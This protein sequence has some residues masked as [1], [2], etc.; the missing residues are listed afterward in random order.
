MTKNVLFSKA[1]NGVRAGYAP[2]GREVYVDVYNMPNIVII[3]NEEYRLI[4]TMSKFGNE[5][6]RIGGFSLVSFLNNI[7][8]RP[9]SDYR[10]EST[11]NLLSFLLELREEIE[12]RHVLFSDHKIK[13]IDEYN[14][15]QE[16]SLKRIVVFA[17]ARDCIRIANRHPEIRSAFALC[18]AAGVF[19]CYYSSTE[20]SDNKLYICEEANYIEF[21]RIK[22]TISEDSLFYEIVDFSIEEKA[23]NGEMLCRRFGI[24]LKD[25]AYY[26][27]VMKRLNII[28]Q[29]N[30][31]KTI[32]GHYP[33]CKTFDEI[34]S[35]MG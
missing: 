20:V 19:L 30:Y 16:D 6:L 4:S 32:I 9:D 21:D 26:M 14:S 33:E 31:Y 18:K 10:E 27:S 7:I 2:N 15:S 28:S 11:E 35:F 8:I 3:D 25:A 22:H 23:V 24:G 13:N 34:R 12:R 5:L 1:Q 17:N 29:N